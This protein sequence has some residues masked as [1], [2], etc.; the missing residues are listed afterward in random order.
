MKRLKIQ[1]SREFRKYRKSFKGQ[2]LNHTFKK[3]DFSQEKL[4]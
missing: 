4:L 3:E 1:K 2:E